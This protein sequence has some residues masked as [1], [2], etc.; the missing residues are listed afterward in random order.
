[1]AFKYVNVLRKNTGKG[2]LSPAICHHTMFRK[3]GCETVF[4]HST[5]ACGPEVR[6][7]FGGMEITTVFLSEHKRM[8]QCDL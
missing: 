4:V 1:M 2:C 7:D 5:G 6:R 3:E 8:R